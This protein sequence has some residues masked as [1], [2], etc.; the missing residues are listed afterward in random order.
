MFGLLQFKMSHKTQKK[1]TNIDSSQ[2]R[3]SQR[4]NND[5]SSR[6]RHHTLTMNYDVRSSGKEK[7]HNTTTVLHY[8]TRARFSKNFMT[9]LRKTY[10]KVWL[11]KNLGWTCDKSYEKLRTNLCKTYEKLT[12]ILRKRKIH[13]KWCHS[14]NPLSEAVIDRIF[15]AKNNWRPEWQFPKN[16]FEKWLTIFL[17]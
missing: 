13:G 14:V 3:Y 1:S 8:A 16:A 12:G 2:R 9:N 10:E 17:R 6:P 11:T 15:W 7:S 5:I 4:A